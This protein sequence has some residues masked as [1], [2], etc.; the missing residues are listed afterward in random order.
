M[1]SISLNI[2][3]DTFSST[4]LL[5]GAVSPSIGNTEQRRSTAYVPA[6]ILSNTMSL[7]PKIDEIRHFMLN[8][9]VDYGCFTETWLSDLIPDNVINIPGYNVTRKDRD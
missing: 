4:P 5:T 8:S 7:A 6:L 3:N 9:S 2:Q 1:H